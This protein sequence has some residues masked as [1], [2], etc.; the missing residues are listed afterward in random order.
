VCE[1][2][3]EETTIIKKR[4]LTRTELQQYRTE[5][6]QKGEKD[7]TYLE[8]I[9]SNGA[10]IELSAAEMKQWA[11]MIGNPH[12]HK[13]LLVA[14]EARINKDLVCLDNRG[15]EEYSTRR[16]YVLCRDRGSSVEEFR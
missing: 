10:D 13:G 3:G 15:V 11:G 6:A 8:R 5:F 2:S 16:E 14:L 4:S 7:V 9:W 12:I 1:E